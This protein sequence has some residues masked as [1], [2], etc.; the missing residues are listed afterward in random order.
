LIF[1]VG[2][3]VFTHKPSVDGGSGVEVLEEDE[4]ETGDIDEETPRR[5]D[6]QQSNANTSEGPYETPVILRTKLW[7][8]PVADDTE[9]DDSEI[10]RDAIMK[11]KK[12]KKPKAV[13]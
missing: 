9:A 2:S 3:E 13:S 12:G 10:E 5:R 4:G 11:R 6:F 1:Q 7:V 8:P